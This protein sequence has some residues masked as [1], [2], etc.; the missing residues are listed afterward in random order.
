MFKY[1]LLFPLLY[2]MYSSTKIY[3]LH[4]CQYMKFNLHKKIEKNRKNKEKLNI[5]SPL[6]QKHL[7]I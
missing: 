3:N 2:T 5:L 4:K 1:F 7:N 6:L